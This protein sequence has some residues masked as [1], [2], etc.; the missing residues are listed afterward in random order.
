MIGSWT[1]LIDYLNWRATRCRRALRILFLDR[2]N[3]LIATRCR[4]AAPSTTRPSTARGGQRAWSWRPRRS[5]GSTTIRWRPDAVP[6]R[7]RHDPRQGDRRAGPGEH[8]RSRP[9]HRRKNRAYQLQVATADLCMARRFA[10]VLGW[11]IENHPRLKDKWGY[12]RCRPPPSL[13]AKIG[14]GEAQ[15]VRAA[16]SEAFEAGPFTVRA[17]LSAARSSWAK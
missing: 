14:A 17:S 5:S 10:C 2:K 6:T 12:R 8:H 4:A 11:A 15:C 16:G 7:H 13:G 1:A 9:H 3:I